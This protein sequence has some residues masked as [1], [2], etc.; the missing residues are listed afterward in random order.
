MLTIKQL[1]AIHVMDRLNLKKTRN[2]QVE[3]R[4]EH[5]QTI[6]SD[7]TDERPENVAIRNRPREL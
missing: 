3:A 4:M 5:V 1:Y 2:A 7:L 6:L